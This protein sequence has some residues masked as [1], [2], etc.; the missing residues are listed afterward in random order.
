MKKST[1]NV[2]RRFDLILF[3]LGGTLIYF[4]GDMEEVNAASELRL[5]SALQNADLRLDL[6]RF[7][8]DFRKRVRSYHQLRDS[9]FVEYTTKRVLGDLLE[10]YHRPGTSSETLE[11]VLAEMYAVS[12]ERWELEED[13]L[14][15]LDILKGQ[16]YHL[17]LVSNASDEEDVRT[18]LK[19]N[20]LAS[21]FE[22]VLV[23]AAVGY[24]KPHPRM[25]QM[26]L[27][28]FQTP[29]EKAVMVGDTQ[30]ADILGANYLGI[31]S[32]WI[33]RRAF[34]PAAGEAGEAIRPSAMIATLAEL[35]DLLANWPG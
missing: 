29:P 9:E 11:R 13:T 23:S 1:K 5:L 2:D 31:S 19:R 10:E 28:A 7:L 30:G 26:A 34:I 25:L 21:R 33:T 35:P 15:T 12:Q 20:R 4:K 8:V 18:L 22:H 6:P 14:P 27:E 16:G 24:R 32:V 17:G 3:D